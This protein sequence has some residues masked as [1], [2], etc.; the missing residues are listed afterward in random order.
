[1]IKTPALMPIML[2]ISVE[3]TTR[4]GHQK[5]YDFESPELARNLLLR[6]LHWRVTDS[7]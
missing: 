4:S 5:F 1:M 2:G 7:N 3:V 6:Y